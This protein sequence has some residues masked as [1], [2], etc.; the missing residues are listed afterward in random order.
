MTTTLRDLTTLHALPQ[1][2]QYR[3]DQLNRISAMDVW[4]D[5]D[6]SANAWDVSAPLLDYQTRYHYDANG[7]L[8]KLKRNA[9]SATTLAMD[10]FTYHY[11]PTNNQLTHVK[12]AVPATNHNQDID[13]QISGNYSYDPSGNLIA[14]Q[15]E[16]IQHISWTTYGKVQSINRVIGSG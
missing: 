3:Y 7:N 10:D 13:D 6:I 8:L 4:Q 12:D 1:G 16:F 14:D 2:A 11:A 15:A 5:L 9:Q